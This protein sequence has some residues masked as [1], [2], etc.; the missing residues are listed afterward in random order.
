MTS[1]QP[2]ASGLRLIPRPPSSLFEQTGFCV[3]RHWRWIGVVAASDDERAFLFERLMQLAM[4]EWRDDPISFRVLFDLFEDASFAFG[5][6]IKR[7]CQ[8]RLMKRKE[9]INAL[10]ELGR[11]TI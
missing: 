10:G 4:S 2:T 11:K 8:A 7:S 9:Q 5:K 6:R 3:I 1:A